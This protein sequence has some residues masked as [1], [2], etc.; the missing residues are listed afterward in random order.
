MDG[1][2]TPTVDAMPPRPPGRSFE[3][4][5][6]VDAPAERVWAIL[7]DVGG[8]GEWNP[9]YPQASG[10]LQPGATI[11]LTVALPGTKPQAFT[12]RVL[13]AVPPRALQFGAPAL[14]GLLYATRFVEL[15]PGPS[16]G[17]TVINGETLSRAMSG[18]L[19]RLAGRTIGEG[20]RGQNEALKAAAE[21]GRDIE[22]GLRT[23][24]AG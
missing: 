16:G 4:S 6:A 12:A 19:A 24:E 3:R 8:W 11:A 14:L 23:S 13:H 15:H 17:C 18:P 2:V 21:D 22:P 10:S 5:I 1:S 9:V 20:L 7:A